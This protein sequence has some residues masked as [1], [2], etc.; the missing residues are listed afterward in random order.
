MVVTS[1]HNDLAKVILLNKLK[2]FE[3]TYMCRINQVDELILG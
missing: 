3:K 1:V 2:E